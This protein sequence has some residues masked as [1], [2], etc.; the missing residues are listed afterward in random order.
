[1]HYSRMKDRGKDRGKVLLS[2]PLS[3][4]VLKEMIVLCPLP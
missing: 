3:F 4:S 1:M 2:S